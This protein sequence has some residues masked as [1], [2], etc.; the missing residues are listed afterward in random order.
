[1]SARE[2]RKTQDAKE[3]PAITVTKQNP[4]L[5]AAVAKMEVNRLGSSRD[6]AGNRVTQLNDT[7]AFKSIL[8]KRAKRNSDA[9]AV[10]QILP[11]IELSAQ[12]LVSSILSPK[13]MT[14][15]E[16]LFM[17]PKNLFSPELSATLLNRI[18]QHFEDGYKIKPLLTDILRDVLFEKGSYP[19]AVIP[20]NAIDDI[21]NSDRAV[22]MESLKDHIDHT[23]KVKSIGILGPHVLTSYPKPVGFSLESHYIKSVSSSIN[24]K[25]HYT[26]EDIK[27]GKVLEFTPCDYLTVTDN[28]S[29]LR[30]P[31]LNKKV[32]EKRVKDI[33]GNNSLNAATEALSDLTVE[34]AI[35]RTRSLKTEFIASV[36]KPHELKRSSVG[37]PLIMKLPSESVI[38]V[39]VPGNLKEH[40]GYFVVLDEEGNPIEV[41]DGDEFHNGL[42]NSASDNNLSSSLIKRVQSNMGSSA[43]FD[44]SN[45]SHIDT[46]NRIYADMVERDLISRMKNGVY[47]QASLIAKNED[48]YRIMLSRVLAKKF[49]QILYI[50]V[51]YMTY[52]AF[53]YTDDGV[54]R[55]LLDDTSIITTLRSV[56]LFADV[57]GAVKN[58]I[59][60]TKVTMNIPEKDPNWAKTLEM[61]QDE[62]VRSRMVNIPL[63]T[64]SVP[65][66]TDYIQRAGYEWEFTGG[67]NLPDLKFDFEEKSSQHAKSDTELQD[68][69]RKAN[70]Q[71]YGLSPEM[72]DSAYNTEFATTAVNNSL[73][74]SKRVVNTQDLFTPMLSDHLRKICINTQALVDDLKNILNENIAN[75]FL[76]I[77]EFDDERATELDEVTKNKLIISKALTVFI[78][79][80][81]VEL[82]RPSS[83]TL[84]DQITDLKGY[85]DAL[86]IALDSYFGKEMFTESS[87]GDIGEQMYTL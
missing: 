27:P 67:K 14:T 28:P 82:P 55:S 8:H 73:L 31:S 15:I 77:E 22:T 83:I 19:V 1:M 48:V 85:G 71:A 53:K 6:G 42:G 65:D 3:F 62:I 69:L 47:A 17:G 30:I 50:P 57:T 75:I 51:E 4:L 79:G 78:N 81:Y 59:G 7:Y 12:I 63:G 16:L 74:L 2:F 37:G 35:F 26:K 70:I 5:A 68:N 11:D 87:A 9:R 39:H 64:S 66:I 45:A 21:I 84:D 40:I 72:V 52:F 36:K 18:K 61:A 13:D 33:Y 43:S 86:D 58:S 60:R 23:G 46:A 10:M 29:V 20:E 34:R 32:K 49:T 76:E 80:F 41:A 24:D 44:G 56:L 38:P 54:G 25:V